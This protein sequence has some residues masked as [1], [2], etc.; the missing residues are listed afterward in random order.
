MD[1]HSKN[2]NA[3]ICLELVGL[4]QLSCFWGLAGGE[5]IEQE[6]DPTYL[7]GVIGLVMVPVPLQGFQVITFK[8]RIFSY[9]LYQNRCA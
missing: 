4:Q 7:P 2:T 9:H 5:F 8:P 1:L 3:S 6:G